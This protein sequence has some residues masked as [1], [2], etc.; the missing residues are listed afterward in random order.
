[1][2]NIL[3]PDTTNWEFC[4][5]FRSIEYW[6]TQFKSRIRKIKDG[7]AVAFYFKNKTKYFMTLT[8]SPRNVL[9]CWKY[10]NVYTWTDRPD[11]DREA[12]IKAKLKTLDKKI[13]YLEDM[14]A[15]Q[16]ARKLK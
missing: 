3:R 7:Y 8:I 4:I 5:K 2:H 6:N 16:E 10:Y 14:L 1:M 9:I 15:K 13:Q 12:Y 11:K